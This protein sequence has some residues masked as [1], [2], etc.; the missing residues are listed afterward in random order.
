MLFLDEPTLGLDVT[1]QA[2]IRDFIRAYNRRYE[3]T[4][5]LTSHYFGVLAFWSTQVRNL[6]SLW[7]GAVLL[8]VLA[9]AFWRFALRYYTGASA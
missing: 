2:T 6:Y 3:A 5:L 4:V 7:Y 9:S 8:F 1:A